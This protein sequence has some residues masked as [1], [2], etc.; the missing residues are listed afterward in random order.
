MNVL[1]VSP[2][3]GG[4]HQAWAEGYQKYS[5]HDFHLLALPA[6][7]WKWR[8][9]GGAVTLAREFSA[10]DFEPDIILATDMLDLSTFLSLTRDRTSRVPA[11]LYM[12]E[13]QLTYPLPD[14]PQTGPMR[15]Q[16]GE[17]DLH[18]A[19]VNYAS[20]LAAS[21]VVFNSEFHRRSLLEALPRF[22]SH[23]PEFRE[24]SSIGEIQ[25]RSCVLPVGLDVAELESA[26]HTRDAEP[27]LL[28]WNQRWEYDKNPEELFKLLLELAD[29][30]IPFEVALCG[31]TF[32]IQPEVLDLTVC[33]LG[34]RVIHR[35]YADTDHYK[36]LLWEAHLT[37]STALHE[38]FGVSILEAA[39]CETLPLLPS[40]LSYP[41]IL[42]L[43]FHGPCLYASHDELVNKLRWAL[44][45]PAAILE[46]ARA[47]AKQIR[48][49]DWQVCAP[50]YDRL[51]E[52]IVKSG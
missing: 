32:Q 31:Q 48:V 14:D 2:Y 37:V 44:T 23:F 10:T 46:T 7:Y 17:R 41:E 21:R 49:Y 45:N 3:H 43:E 40:R 30:G 8:I 47:L 38:F 50:S 39:V 36:R 26:R 51:L 29:E 19:F 34:K 35:G 5:R 28:L 6:R 18:Y 12:H 33:K 52:D 9:H 15:R 20:M 25:A 13:N 22:L 24:P 42:P 1:L 4:S 16:R 11:V 27:P